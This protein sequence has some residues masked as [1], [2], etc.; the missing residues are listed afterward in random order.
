MYTYVQ[1]IYTTHGIRQHCDSP[2]T[3]SLLCSV[4][5]TVHRAL[6]GGYIHLV[7][8]EGQG[9]PACPTGETARAREMKAC[10]WPHQRHRV[11]EQ[12]SLGLLT[13]DPVLCLWLCANSPIVGRAAAFPSRGPE[14]APNHQH[15]AACSAADCS[16]IGPGIPLVM[17]IWEMD[18]IKKTKVVSRA[19]DSAKGS[20]LG[21]RETSPEGAGT[22][23]KVRDF[24]QA[25][26]R[27]SPFI[28][29]SS[30]FS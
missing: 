15:P 26:S 28:N 13:P 8:E 19:R 30:C 2:P 5:F 12:D 22:A 4:C 1:C 17:P 11:P 6:I 23:C 20:S 14:R 24:P 16:L 3:P 25:P 10:P 27:S 18:P 7:R 21:N 9:Y 29:G